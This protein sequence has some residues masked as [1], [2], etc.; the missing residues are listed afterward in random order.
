MQHDGNTGK[1]ENKELFKV[2]CA[3]DRSI[4]VLFYK[5]KQFLCSFLP[6]AP[7]D[8]DVQSRYIS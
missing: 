3:L 7:I 5:K 1:L 4:T 6:Y 2:F 8:N